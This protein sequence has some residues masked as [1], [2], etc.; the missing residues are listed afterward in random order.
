[1]LRAQATQR[2]AKKLRHSWSELPAPFFCSQAGTYPD[3][4]NVR[5]AFARVVK[6]AKLPHFTPHSLRHTFASLLLVAGTDV[7]VSRMLGHASIQETVDTY[8]RWLPANRPGALDVLDI[9]AVTP[10]LVTNP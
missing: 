5:D 2:K 7:Y 9:P 4:R 10:D 3:P 8:G 6:A 1:V